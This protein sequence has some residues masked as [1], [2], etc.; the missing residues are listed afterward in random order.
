MM[1]VWCNVFVVGKNGDVSL[2]EVLLF[3]D[4]LY[5]EV[6]DMVFFSYGMVL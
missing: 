4:Y 6:F 1:R 5:D 2:M 3:L